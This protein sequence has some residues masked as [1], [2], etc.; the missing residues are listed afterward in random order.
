MGRAKDMLIEEEERI[1]Q[2]QYERAMRRNLRCGICDK[3]I[4]EE[5]D[6]SSYN[7]DGCCNDCA[8][9]VSKED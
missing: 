6:N 1:A 3:L 9:R 7:T 5:A 8:N 4:I 2:A